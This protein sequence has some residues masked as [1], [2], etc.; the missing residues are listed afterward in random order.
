MMLGLGRVITSIVEAAH[1]EYEAWEYACLARGA[2]REQARAFNQAAYAYA[3]TTI[4][5]N[6][7]V[8]DRLR[9]V[10][11]QE[12]ACGRP[13]PSVEEAIEI[14]R[15]DWLLSQIRPYHQH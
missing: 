15:R 13:F 9:F 4:E 8:V 10:A 12:L 6:D 14:N 5:P 2:T 3:T 1:A 7:A 11:K